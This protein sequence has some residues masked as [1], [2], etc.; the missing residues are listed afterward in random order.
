MSEVDKS[1]R[2]M[3]MGTIPPERNPRG[4][5][6]LLAVL[7]IYTIILPFLLYW[8]VTSFLESSDPLILYFMP[9]IIFFFGA[10]SYILL[11]NIFSRYIAPVDIFMSGL[12]ALQSD[13]SGL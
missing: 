1:D 9:I 10:F 7:G 13:D 4:K 11:R 8:I 6:I 5:K 2:G 12:L 3:L